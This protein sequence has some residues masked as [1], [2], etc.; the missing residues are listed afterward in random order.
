MVRLIISLIVLGTMYGLIFGFSL[1][2]RHPLLPSEKIVSLRSALDQTLID[3]STFANYRGTTA[4][5]ADELTGLNSKLNGDS[6]RLQVALKQA[7]S[8]VD[9]SL[10]SSVQTLINAQQA[11]N[12]TFAKASTVL[13][14]PVAYDP[15]SDLGSLDLNR[16]HD[17]AITRATAAQ[18]GL[19]AAANNAVLLNNSQA[20]SIN[21]QQAG[22]APAA[23]PM[24]VATGSKSALLAA[25]NCFGQLAS[26]LKA[27][28]LPQAGQT[29]TSCIQNYPSTRQTVIQNLIHDSLPDSYQQQLRTTYP[30]LLKQL[31]AVAKAASAAQ[32][33]SK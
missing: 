5:S 22:Q 1:H 12:T 18:N 27:N 17:E 14:H 23:A 4:V 30:S 8:T 16:N 32:K 20:D 28:Q 9:H 19:K 21:V 33:P 26:E 3:S 25:S 2:R 13:I 15:E 31:D 7:P 24:I 6:A 29:R 10:R 11:V